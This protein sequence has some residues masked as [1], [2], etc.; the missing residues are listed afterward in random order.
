MET[1][2]IPA[3]RRAI[4]A[5]DGKTLVGFYADD[6]VLQID[7]QNIQS[8]ELFRGWLQTSHG[9]AIEAECPGKSAI[10]NWVH[11]FQIL[12]L[13]KPPVFGAE[14]GLQLHAG[15]LHQFRCVT[16]TRID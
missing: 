7:E 16:Q 8:G 2:T 13:A 1:V 14:N 6:A 15:V 12:G 5:R 10:W 9:A 4:E 3:L 11:R